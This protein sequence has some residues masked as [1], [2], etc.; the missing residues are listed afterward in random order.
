MIIPFITGLKYLRKKE[1]CQND[2]RIYCFPLKIKANKL[3]VF[4]SQPQPDEKLRK[5]AAIDVFN[6]VK[7]NKEIFLVV[8]LHPAEK[9]DFDYY[10]SIAKQTGCNNYKLILDVDLYLLL[11]K[12]DIL[13]TC[14]STV[15]AEAIYFNKPFISLDYLNEDLLNY[16]KEGIAFKATNGEELKVCIENIL[17]NKLIIDKNA[18][19]RYIENYAF[20]IDGKVADRIIEII[21][22]SGY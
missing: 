10:H 13:I 8:K 20:K 15:G 7:D 3:I 9:H 19:Q 22:N 11:S 17:N 16:H 4:A 21:R 14:F 6:A 5:Q 18:H 2:W 12:T 1:F